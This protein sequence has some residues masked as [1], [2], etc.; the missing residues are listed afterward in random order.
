MTAQGLLPSGGGKKLGACKHRATALPSRAY[1]RTLQGDC[2]PHGRAKSSDMA[3]PSHPI[4][5]F[6]SCHAPSELPN[7]PSA[8]RGLRGGA[9]QAGFTGVRSCW[10]M[11]LM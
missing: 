6:R 7:L 5:S 10:R 2:G 4:G 11:I 1:A 3:A 9:G 8:L